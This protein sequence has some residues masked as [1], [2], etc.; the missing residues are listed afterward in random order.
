MRYDPEIGAELDRLAGRDPLG[1]VDPIGLLERGRRGRRRRRIVS[2]T[3][4]AAGAA[5]IALGAALVPGIGSAH[6][7]PEVA[8]T[9]QALFTPMPGVRQGEAALG[10]ITPAEA[11]RRC[12]VRY[13][14]RPL[15]KFHP[16]VYRATMGIMSPLPGKGNT[17]SPECVVPGDS[18]PTAAAVAK[19]KAD[20]MPRTAD[21]QLLNCSVQLWHDLTKWRV[22]A[23]ERIE[24]ARN[25]R[26]L[27]MLAVSPTG[28]SA[29]SCDLPLADETA[30][31][32][33]SSR[34]SIRTVQDERPMALSR[35]GADFGGGEGGCKSIPCRGW[36]YY[37][38]GRVDPAITRIHLK[39][40]NGAT[41]DVTVANGWF[42]LYWSNGDLKGRNAATLTAY[43]AAG[44]VIGTARVGRGA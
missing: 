22:V 28:R 37:N 36:T 15:A 33:K 12:A 34:P 20:P 23:T 29:V 26:E 11:E 3:G 30:F 25:G 19:A 40:A 5:A 18:R 6:R 31:L 13:G 38:Y 39:A 14:K 8:G 10:K 21:G 43:N 1:P 17:F 32:A 35:V 41:H 27:R 42:V 2:V 4:L 44:Q 7:E 9:G 16:G 24:G